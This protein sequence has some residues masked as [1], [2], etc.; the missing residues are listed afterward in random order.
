ME[1]CL[2][3]AIG[4]L[5]L[6]V[7]AL[8]LKIHYMH[9]AAQEIE[10]AFAERLITD[11]NTLMGI[12]SRDKYMR[13]LAN[14]INSQLRI[15]RRERRRFHQG[16][17][18]LK[19]AVTNISHD[20]RTPLTAVCGYLDLLEWEKK[21]P[22]AERYV[23]IIR[24]RTEVMRQLTEELFRYSVLSSPDYGVQVETVSIGEVLEESIAGYYATLQAHKITPDIRMPERKVM[25]S[26]N[27]AALSRIFANLLNNAVKYSS[28]DLDITLTEKGEIIF[29]NTAT[30]LDE[31][32]VGKLFDRFYTVET[33]RKSTGLGLSIAKLLVEQ[34]HGII[35]AD[36]REQRLYIRIQL[37]EEGVG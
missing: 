23:D 8:L 3:V 20:L 13:H 17:L 7:A 24:D 30:E 12:S 27:R 4:I 21:S 29:A 9:K 28:G 37:S 1:V 5:I 36:Y 6:C 25:R 26:L 22:Q 2:W 34:M 35:E 31:V 11:T 16:D 19:S 15:L 10:E 14:E 18:E 33:G 32:Q